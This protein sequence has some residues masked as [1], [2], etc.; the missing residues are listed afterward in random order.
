MKTSK[1]EL[2]IQLDNQ[3]VPENISWNATDSP[4]GKAEN[5]KAIALAVWDD[6]NHTT[7]K[8]DLWTKDMPVD[9]MKLFY[10]E[11]I[12]GMSETLLSATADEFMYTEIK[13]LCEKLMQHM[14]DDFKKRQ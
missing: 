14:D 5:T 6:Q 2:H 13:K 4:S 8:I 3:N 10:I 1:I 7:M 9:E 11:T 12:G